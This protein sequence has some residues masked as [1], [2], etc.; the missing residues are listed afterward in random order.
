MTRAPRST[1]RF[2][3]AIWGDS[4]GGRVGHVGPP[5]IQFGECVYC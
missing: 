2:E 3:P 5:S 1:R 4:S